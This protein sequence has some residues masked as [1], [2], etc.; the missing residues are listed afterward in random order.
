VSVQGTRRDLHPIVREEGFLVSREALSNA[1]RHA[2]AGNI[3]AEVTYGDAALHIRIRDDGQGIGSAVLEAGERPGH[4]GLIGM[5]ERAKKLGANLEVWSKPG[6]GTE[7]DLRVP[8]DVAYRRLQTES[9]G[10]RTWLALFGSSA[11]EH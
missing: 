10:I 8:A 4:F 11:Q 3:E 1:F 9:R 2:H 7:V 5:R 6:A